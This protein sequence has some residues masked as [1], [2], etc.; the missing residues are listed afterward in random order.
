MKLHFNIGE[1]TIGGIVQVS[2]RPRGVFEVK[3][4]DSR[5]KLTVQWRF[6]HG[7]DELESYLE[8]I[9]TPYWADKMVT[10]INKKLNVSKSN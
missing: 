10:K 5:T 9:S 4:M 8:E 2:T 1:E 7:L 6:V 3:S